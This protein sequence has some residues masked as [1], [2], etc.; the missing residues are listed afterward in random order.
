MPDIISIQ[1]FDASQPC[2]TRSKLGYNCNLKSRNLVRS[3]EGEQRIGRSAAGYPVQVV[4]SD[5]L[6]WGA[7]R[8]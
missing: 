1:A 3:H 5:S 6:R 2:A 4:M 7:A 8:C